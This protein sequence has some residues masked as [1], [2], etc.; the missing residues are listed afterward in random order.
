MSLLSKYAPD[1]GRLYRLA[2]MI[3]AMGFVLSGCV[4]VQPYER[5]YLADPLMQVEEYAED[6]AYEAHISRA[7][8][9]SNTGQTVTGGAGCGCEQ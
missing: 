6:S 9:Q 4:R 7:L 1:R 5:E 2:L 3:L 8:S